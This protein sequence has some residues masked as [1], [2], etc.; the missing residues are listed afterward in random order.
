MLS[1]LILATLWLDY[2]R[3]SKLLVVDLKAYLSAKHNCA[4]QTWCPQEDK[5]VHARLYHGLDAAQHEDLSTLQN[6]PKP[7]STRS[8]QLKLSAT[9]IL[10]PGSEKIGNS[11]KMTGIEIWHLA[12]RHEKVWMR[13]KAWCCGR[14]FGMHQIWFPTRPFS[15][16]QQ[17]LINSLE[18]MA[19][20]VFSS[21]H[22]F[23]VSGVN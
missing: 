15:F 8:C 3:F 6:L 12:S 23:V 20:F 18:S 7:F 16:F 17:D 10:R 13:K 19:A 14:H 11:F 9:V 21:N 4:W 1:A 22:Q 2:W 5:D